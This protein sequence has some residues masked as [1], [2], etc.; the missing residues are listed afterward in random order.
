MFEAV[1][2]QPKPPCSGCYE[3]LRCA[4][5]G[6]ACIDF[7]MYVHN[8]PYAIYNANRQPSK[9]RYLTVFKTTEEDSY[10]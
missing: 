2:H 5:Q 8:R 9:G 3:R 10:V 1:A 7:S 6:L 4:S